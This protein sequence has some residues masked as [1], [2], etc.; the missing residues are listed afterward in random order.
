MG[1]SLIA[2]A[3]T[4]EVMRGT[5]PAIP[6]DATGDGVVEI[7]DEAGAMRGVVF[8]A[9]A[10]KAWAG[11]SVRASA[12]MVPLATG[13]NLRS[14]PP[15]R[16]TIRPNAAA[17]GGILLKSTC[18]V[19]ALYARVNGQFCPG[20]GSSGKLCSRFQG[21]RASRGWAVSSRRWKRGCR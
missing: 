12:K 9:T 21:W 19:G 13:R 15:P 16:A 3:F 10:G 20:F 8:A 7:D 2:P 6:A 14:I 17:N 11:S 1:Y 18:I 5:V 4:E